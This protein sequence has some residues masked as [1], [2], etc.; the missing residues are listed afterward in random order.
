M[1]KS[2]FGLA[3]LVV[4]V[5]AAQSHGSITKGSLTFDDNAFADSAQM[6]VGSIDSFDGGATDVNDA[7][8]GSDLSKMFGLFE[9]DGSEIVEVSF[10]D[11]AIY[12]GAGFDLVVYEMHFAEGVKLAVD[13]GGGVFS[14]Y[15]S[16][17]AAGEGFI[18]GGTVNAAR[19]NL[20]AFGL[21]AGAIVDTIRIMPDSNTPELSG[22]AAFNNTDTVTVI[23]EPST[24]IA[25]SLLGGLGI[26][27]WWRRR[28]R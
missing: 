18:E 16:F 11:N 23:P 21:G 17:G 8:T 6:I 24:F 27:G 26:I 4:I 1:R 7:L 22:A 9:F 3:A 20:D 19:I 14:S 2:I 28:S 10:T 5:V 12:N 15:L 25:W 13:L